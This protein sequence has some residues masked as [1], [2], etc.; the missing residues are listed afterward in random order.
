MSRQFE[1]NHVKRTIY[2]YHAPAR[3]VEQAYDVRKDIFLEGIDLVKIHHLVPF[4]RAFPSGKYNRCRATYCS[5][6]ETYKIFASRK[7]NVTVRDWKR[8]VP[9][10]RS[11]PQHKP[12]LVSPLVDP[13]IRNS[14]SDTITYIFFSIRLEISF[15]DMRT[16][17]PHIQKSISR[18]A[19]K[20][21]N[22]IRFCPKDIELTDAQTSR[23]RVS[24]FL[25]W[26]LIWILLTARYDWRPEAASVALSFRRARSW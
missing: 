23:S 16:S 21:Q 5:D 20:T 3:E 2:A 6:Q 1:S 4:G 9:F 11:E 14:C 8:I 22:R 18:A 13:S 12:L 26:P 15:P 17:N 25:G 19:A 24:F 10:F 7:T